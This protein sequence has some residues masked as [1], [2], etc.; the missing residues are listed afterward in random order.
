MNIPVGLVK[1]ILTDAITLVTSHSH[2][3]EKLA[4]QILAY[5][6]ELEVYYKDDKELISVPE[7]IVNLL[8]KSNE[9]K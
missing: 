9:L 8:T 2:I 7:T 1:Q 3:N 6:T 5:R 4:G